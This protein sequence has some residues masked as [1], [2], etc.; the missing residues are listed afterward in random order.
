MKNFLLLNIVC[1][2]IPIITHSQVQE[3]YKEDF[4]SATLGEIGSLNQVMLNK[5]TPQA[6]PNDNQV[7]NSDFTYEQENNSNKFAQIKGHNGYFTDN[8]RSLYYIPLNQLWNNRT[9]G[10][11]ILTLEWKM[12]LDANSTSIG[13]VQAGINATNGDVIGEIGYNDQDNQLFFASER[14]GSD[15]HEKHFP[16][17]IGTSNNIYIPTNQWVELY[18]SYNFNTGEIEFKISYQDSNQANN[19]FSHFLNGNNIN[20]EQ[21]V[22][23]SFYVSNRTETGNTQSATIKIDDIVLS[24]KPSN[25][26]NV[27]E[28]SSTN[29]LKTVIYPNPCSDY[30]N[31][32][33]ANSIS[34][35]K[36]YDLTGKLLIDNNYKD[37]SNKTIKIDIS[38]FENG[39][40]H[41]LTKSFDGSLS[42]QIIIKN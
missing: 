23:N 21:L 1:L 8:V 17:H 18:Y 24:A 32:S 34:Q 25:N 6:H 14:K 16:T 36:V 39:S 9:N 10:Y 41:V 42:D 30:V 33:N 35:V 7:S 13:S 3:L 27:S 37:S 29:Q 20:K 31:L 4:N 22:P 38:H 40:Y 26:L 11:D 19:S 12:F 2:L 5:V 15:D 28:L